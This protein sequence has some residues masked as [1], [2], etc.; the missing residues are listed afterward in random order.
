[1]LQVVNGMS[2]TTSSAW[3]TAAQE[4]FGMSGLPENPGNLTTRWSGGLKAHLEVLEHEGDSGLNCKDIQVISSPRKPINPSL[5]SLERAVSAR[6]FF[7]NLYL[8]LLRH[9]PSREQRRVA[10]EK[11]MM[12]MQLSE[13]QKEH[14]R[15]RWQQNET[16]YLRDRRRKIDA[17]A[18]IKLKTIGHGLNIF[19]CLVFILAKL[20]F[21]IHSIPLHRRFRCSLTGER[22]AHRS[23]LCYE[24]GMYFEYVFLSVSP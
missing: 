17:S 19:F 14:L 5:S 6:I 20:I 11:D 8:P 7:E 13:P 16:D 15:A 4:N 2:T 3:T 18:F 12:N 23:T 24:A 1:M 9:P 21:M 22:A 10:M